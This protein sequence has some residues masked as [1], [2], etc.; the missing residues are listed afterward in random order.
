MPKRLS[1]TP[2]RSNDPNQAAFQMVNKFSETTNTSDAKPTR[3]EISRF[4]S[5]MGRKGGKKSAK[6]RMGP[7]GI[8]A[9]KRSEIALKAAKARWAKKQ[10]DQGSSVRP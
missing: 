1:S 4:M 8:P 6:A 10:D 5:A 7:N 9:E 3:A 2:K